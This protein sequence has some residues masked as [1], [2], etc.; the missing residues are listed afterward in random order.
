MAGIFSQIQNQKPVAKRLSCRLARKDG[1]TR[2]FA[3]D[4]QRHLEGR[5][6]VAIT[7][8]NRRNHPT[9]PQV[10]QQIVLSLDER[11]PERGFSLQYPV[12]SKKSNYTR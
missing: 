7:H 3:E 11:H 6:K 9:G 10:L 5:R 8:V 2:R 1:L 12:Y 4:I